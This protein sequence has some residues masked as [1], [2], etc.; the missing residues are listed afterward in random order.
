MKLIYTIWPKQ[1]Y[2][3]LIGPE[4]DFDQK[5]VDILKAKEFQC[6]SL[7]KSVLR[8]ETAGIS[9]CNTLNM[10]NLGIPLAP[11]GGTTI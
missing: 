3:V 10:I 7:G 6:I 4:G 9:V 1:K 2:L 8:T 11:D 5:E